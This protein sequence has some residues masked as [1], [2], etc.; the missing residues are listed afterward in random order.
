M[1]F[2]AFLLRGCIVKEEH[3]LKATA[4]NGTVSQLA[5]VFRPIAG[6]A[7][8]TIGSYQICLA[9]NIASFLLSALLLFFAKTPFA[10]EAK[11]PG[12]PWRIHL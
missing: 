10:N 8:V 7:P 9:I 4:M 5:K 1:L 6:A 12:A 11:P 3:G 2:A